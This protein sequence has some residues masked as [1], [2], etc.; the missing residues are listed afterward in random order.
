[1]A[2]MQVGRRRVKSGLDPQRPARLEPLD[3]LC[4]HQNFLGTSPD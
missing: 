2:E 4:L 3:Q 1:M